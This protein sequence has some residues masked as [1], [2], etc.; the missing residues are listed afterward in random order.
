MI[1]T[2]TMNPSVDRSAV[3]ATALTLGAVNRIADS[4]DSPGGKGINVARVLAAGGTEAT[5]VFPAPAHDPFVAMCAAAGVPAAVVPAEGPVRVNLTLADPDGTTTKINAPGPVATPEM[6]DR[7]RS[8][9]AAL[10]A[11]ATWVVL[12]GSLPGGVSA[13]FYAD[14]VAE[15]RGTGARLAVDTSD[16]PLA[17][18]AA[19]FPSAAP[20]LVKP[21]GEELGQLA[22]VDGVELERRAADGDLAPVVE[23]AR[24][25]R[26]SGVGTVLVT[27]GGAGAVLVGGGDDD[28]ADGEAWFAT[29]PPVRVRS[30]VGAGDSALA[31]Y[32]LADARGLPPAERLAWAVSHGSVAASLAGTGLP[33]GLD[34]DTF[35][36]TV[37]RLD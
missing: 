37:R 2:L 13:G 1:V 4:H 11:K 21:N 22:G 3:L 25:L 16:A 26:A 30:T 9:V 12:S 17:A 28:D 8:D 15:L 23:T 35:R 18:L 29:T 27:L 5:A 7:V 10:A 14:L 33:L 19:R 32:L 36:A 31:G 20:D 24:T 6:L 34:P